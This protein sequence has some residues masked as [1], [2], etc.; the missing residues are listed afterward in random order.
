MAYAS[1]FMPKPYRK[2]S[3]TPLM[4]DQI[5]QCCNSKHFRNIRGHHNI[6]RQE[7]TGERDQ[8]HYTHSYYLRFISTKLTLK[9]E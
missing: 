9:M 8:I 3:E 5:S 4:K 7:A 2:I 1:H 6:W